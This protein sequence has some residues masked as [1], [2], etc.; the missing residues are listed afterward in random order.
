MD[1]QQAKSLI[2]AYADGELEASA[3]L[4]LEKHLATC[5][6][7][8]SAWQNRQRL[9]K[10]LKQDA[11]FFSAP[12]DFRQKIKAD[13]RAEIGVA[14]WWSVLRTKWFAPAFGAVLASCALLLIVNHNNSAET[15][16]TQEIVSNHV[17]SLMANHILDVVSTDQHTV[18]PWFNGKLDF[19]PPVKDL[20]AQEFPLIGGRLDYV[21]GHTAAALVFQHRKHII[22]LFIWPAAGNDA[23]PA[24]RPSSQGFNVIRWKSGGMVF[25]AVSDLNSK[26]L[27]EFSQDYARD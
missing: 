14:P 27:L 24:E 20:A 10:A 12:N 18:K 6:N 25:W 13:L 26:E 2:D 3:I 8:A 16:L 15:R 9:K 21:A 22:N 17:R 4:D 5:P 7:C 19:S 1:C 23:L 11:V